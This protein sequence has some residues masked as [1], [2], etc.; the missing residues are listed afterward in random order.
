MSRARDIKSH[1]A[2]EEGELEKRIVKALYETRWSSQ[3]G[4]YFV[5]PR[6]YLEDG[7]L[8]RF[9]SKGNAPIPV[10]LLVERAPN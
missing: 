1:R 9:E 8:L 4:Y 7:T 3:T 6:L 2:I 5:N 10:K